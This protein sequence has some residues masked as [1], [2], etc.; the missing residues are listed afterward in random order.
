MN[1]LLD[2]HSFLWFITADKALS[3]N[4]KT[5]IEDPNNT[6]FLSLASVWEMAIKSSLGKLTIPQPFAAFII[7]QLNDNSFS[8]L[9][10]TLAH[11]SIVST[12]PF[13]H[14]DPFDR[15]LIAQALHEKMPIIGNENIFDLYG[16]TRKW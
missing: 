4:A 14:R 8:L 12:S 1:Y 16:I 13:H 6:I 10:I 2:T 9:P 15:L 5:L 11:A 7:K 3:T